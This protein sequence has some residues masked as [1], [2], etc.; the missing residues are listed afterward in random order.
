MLI[1]SNPKG[2]TPDKKLVSSE[3]A[4]NFANYLSGFTQG[5]KCREF[6]DATAT[7]YSVLFS[8]D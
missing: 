6:R 2:D 5:R 1:R 7:S 3:P 8:Q 4:K